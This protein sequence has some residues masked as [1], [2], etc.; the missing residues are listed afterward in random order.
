M[1]KM[2]EMKSGDGRMTGDRRM[3]AS[4]GKR[5]YPAVMLL[6]LISLI[7]SS[8]VCALQISPGTKTLAP[9]E[10]SYTLRIINDQQQAF[11]V[12]I[13]VDGELGASVTVSPSSL[14]FT[15]QDGEESVVVTLGVDPATLR[16][17]RNTATV[18]VT[19]SPGQAGQFGGATEL[20][21]TLVVYRP[22]EGAFIEGKLMTGVA[23][24]EPLLALGL[25][26]RGKQ[27]TTVSADV[28]VLKPDKSQLAR[29]SL[30]TVEVA[31]EA[32]A[33]LEQAARLPPGSYTANATF[34]YEDRSTPVTS[35]V[36]APVV[37]GSPTVLLSQQ[38]GALAP[39]KTSKVLFP[40]EVDWN[41]PVQVYADVFLLK[42]DAVL[43]NTR[44]P[45]TE[46]KPGKGE[47]SAYLEVPNV[48]PGTFRLNATVRNADGRI[49]G[50]KEWTVLVGTGAPATTAG[51]TPI[52]GISGSIALLL[53]FFITLGLFVGVVVYILWK[54]R[55][56]NT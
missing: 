22:Y 41:E 42:E 8:A 44:T 50:S 9:G 33:K 25:V 17:G 24:A 37:L 34:T 40:T 14:A 5:T 11:A 52:T 13:N 29:I 1:D 54:N 18:L 4:T 55:D 51:K 39:K 12:G 10:E 28:T 6:I 23:N 20:V 7:S 36:S 47:L 46:L 31:G 21:H 43:A 53:T 26:N 2:M 30:G 56:K 32:E 38:F 15:P 48:I 35:S 27:V 16:P 45:T 49:L 3:T 19:A